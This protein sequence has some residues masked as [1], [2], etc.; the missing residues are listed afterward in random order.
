VVEIARRHKGDMTAAI[1]GLLAPARH[2]E[3]DAQAIALAV[4]GAIVRS[5]CDETPDAALKALSRFI[6]ALQAEESSV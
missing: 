4:D 1:A 5:Q 2:R 6:K 3:K